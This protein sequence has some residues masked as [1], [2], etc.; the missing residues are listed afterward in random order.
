MTSRRSPGGVTSRLVRGIGN[1]TAPRGKGQR[2]LCIVTYHRILAGPD[3]L[4]DEEPDSA[5]FRWQMEVLA[6]CFNVLPLHGAVHMPGPNAYRRAQ[7]R[8]RSKRLSLGARPGLCPCCANIGC[9]DAGCMWNDIIL[10][11]ICSLP[12][13]SLDLRTMDQDMVVSLRCA[14]LPRR[15]ASTATI[16]TSAMCKW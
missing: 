9:L 1:S 2:R 5:S 3:P 10:E 16:S 6:E 12:G 11:S 7:S 4:L 13:S 15:T 8:S 14:C